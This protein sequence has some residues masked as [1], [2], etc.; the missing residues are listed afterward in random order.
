MNLFAEYT[1]AFS[2]MAVV[3]VL[4]GLALVSARA[5]S[6]TEETPITHWL[7]KWVSVRMFQV[8]SIACFLVCCYC[9]IVESI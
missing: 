5:Y 3:I 6:S 7:R 9:I 8:I 1:Q 2:V 4:G